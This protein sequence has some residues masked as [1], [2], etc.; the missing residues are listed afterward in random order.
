[1][2]GDS[3]KP[4]SGTRMVQSARVL[5]PWSQAIALGVTGPS[6]VQTLLF[7]VTPKQKAIRVGNC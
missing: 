7:S 6:G 5:A 3:A 4:G 2:A 1:V